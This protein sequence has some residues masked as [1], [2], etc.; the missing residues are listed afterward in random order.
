MAQYAA[1]LRGVSPMNCKKPELK[2]EL[3]KAG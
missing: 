3:E 1:L 2:H